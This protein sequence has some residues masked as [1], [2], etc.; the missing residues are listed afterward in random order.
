M[1]NIAKPTVS[2]QRQKIY[3]Q[4]LE[5]SQEGDLNAL[6]DTG[7]IN[8]SNDNLD[9]AFKIFTLTSEKGSMRG[10][11]GVA[12]FLYYGKGTKQ[13]YQKSYK[14]FCELARDNEE[15]K[16]ICIDWGGYGYSDNFVKCLSTK[17]N[18]A[19][20]SR[21][22]EHKVRNLF[23]LFKIIN[24]TDNYSKY[25][26]IDVIDNIV[27]NKNGV[28]VLDPKAELC[29]IT[30]QYLESIGQKVYVFDPTNKSDLANC[31]INVLD[32]LPEEPKEKI[33]AIHGLSKLICPQSSNYN[34][35]EQYFTD[36]ARTCI[37]LVLLHLCFDKCSK[38]DCNLG[39]VYEILI[40]PDEEFH[41]MLKLCLASDL[42][43]GE[44]AR[45]AN[46]ILAI[47]KNEF[48]A[49]IHTARHCL[50]FASSSVGQEF[51]ITPEI[52][53]DNQ[54]NLFLCVG[55]SNIGTPDQLGEL[56]TKFFL[57]NNPGNKLMIS[58]DEKREA[59]IV[60]K[61]NNSL[62]KYLKQG[63]IFLQDT[64]NNLEKIQIPREYWRQFC[65]KVA[66]LNKNKL[67][68]QTNISLSTFFGVN[69][70]RIEAFFDQSNMSVIIRAG[71]KPL[72]HLKEI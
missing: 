24:N 66:N 64:S 67:S 69:A 19:K 14:Y 56:V 9:K 11:L 10:K 23:N 26:G 35:T 8:Y 29:N 50:K 51:A 2:E 5:L 7:Y 6:D 55:T 25:I 12:L 45:L 38:E 63:D 3:A 61:F 15:I 37:E 47:I 65:I 4:I 70:N 58:H 22:I 48:S 57:T 17:E 71:N 16:N 31:K 27:N 49:V 21:K 46:I 32:F 18:L 28:L 43:N 54:V 36:L 20:N 72:R 30:K 68:H 59:D 39:K 62:G 52:L 44:I 1:K 41:E 60:N 13:D 42:A 33:I 34:Y 53:L 40:A